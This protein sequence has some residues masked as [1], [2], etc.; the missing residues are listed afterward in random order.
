MVKQGAG[1]FSL[2]GRNG[3]SFGDVRDGNSIISERLVLAYPQLAA[4]VSS[5]TARA[6]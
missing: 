1:P 2:S 4:H 3:A 5:L 6:A